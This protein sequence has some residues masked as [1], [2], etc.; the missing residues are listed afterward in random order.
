MS[1]CFWHKEFK[2]HLV[3]SHYFIIHKREKGLYFEV[4]RKGKENFV[5]TKFY[6]AKWFF[7]LHKNFSFKKIFINYS[8]KNIFFTVYPFLSSSFLPWFLVVFGC[9]PV[10][11]VATRLE[12]KAL[13]HVFVFILLLCSYCAHFQQYLLS[14]FSLVFVTAALNVATSL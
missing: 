5:I 9:N 12:K 10:A 6:Q 7:L 13:L 4:K 1:I 2:N 3:T 8:R 11:S 14:H